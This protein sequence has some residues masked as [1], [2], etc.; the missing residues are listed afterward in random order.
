[1]D[2]LA[3]LAALA[4]LRHKYC[5]FRIW[6]RYYIGSNPTTSKIGPA[7]CAIFFARKSG[8][9]NEVAQTSLHAFVS[10]KSSSLKTEGFLHIFTYT[11]KSY[12]L[13]RFSIE[14][15]PLCYSTVGLHYSGSIRYRSTSEDAP[16]NRLWSF[17]LS[18]VRL[19]LKFIFLYL[20][21]KK[22]EVALVRR[23]L[24]EGGRLY[25]KDISV[26]QFP[27]NIL[28]FFILLL[29]I[30]KNHVNLYKM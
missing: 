5:S 28:I 7:G 30:F 19:V 3:L 29:A 12:L 17:S 1:M 14:F 24:G 8:K 18:G 4:L 20:I 13:S 21:L 16:F 2:C 23:N 11:K 10:N 9:K 22:N 25:I 27:Q 15:V 26:L 6:C